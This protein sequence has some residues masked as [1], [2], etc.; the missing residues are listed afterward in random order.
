MTDAAEQT[1]QLYQRAEFEL[2][3]GLIRPDDW[4]ERDPEEP[5]R[6]RA[7]R[8]YAE[9]ERFLAGL[10]DP[11][12]SFPSVLI[13]GTSGKGSVATLVARAL[14][15]TGLR[16]G[17]HTS[18]YL[19]V[20]TEKIVIDGRYLDG[21]SFAELVAWVRPHALA[22]RTP[23]ATASPHGMASV[24]IAYEAFRRAAIDIAV[25][26][27]GMGGRYDLNNHVRPVACCVTTVGLDH[28]VTLGPTLR[29]IAWHKAGVA[30]A[31]VP[32]VSGA[33]GEAL[34]VVREEAARVG[35]PLQVVA[36]DAAAFPER[37]LTLARA[38]LRIL[39]EPF[40]V[41]ELD[42]AALDRERLMP[43]RLETLPHGQLI[44]DGA[45]NPDK[46]RALVG[47]L[48]GRGVQRPVVLFGQLDCKDSGPMLEA[49]AGLCDR[50]VL[51]E[52]QVHEKPSVPAAELAR[53][54]TNLGVTAEAEPDPL[55]ALARARE[56][57]SDS[58]AVVVTGSLY[59]L[60]RIRETA[61]PA[62]AVLLQRTSW[63]GLGACS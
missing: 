24:A 29:D 9:V 55:A 31:G 6:E 58:Q 51:T 50:M 46:M 8:K 37:N 16:V 33:E 4:V 3:E 49:L 57:A 44:L 21:E 38:L 26:E 15:S 54:A 32:L 11:Q 22:A 2:N 47:A 13:A 45:H 23:Q 41:T 18:P 39:P 52:P 19:Q 10:G 27:I 20:A 12:H 48:R 42:P 60:G 30:R 25:I 56:L 59:L 40:R 5:P 43:G 36:P 61:F 7:A 1:W 62:R 28:L 63:P 14:Q 34:D 53:I 35:A 17:L